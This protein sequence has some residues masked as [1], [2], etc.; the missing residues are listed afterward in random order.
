MSIEISVKMS[1][2]M[3]LESREKGTTRGDMISFSARLFFSG[4]LIFLSSCFCYGEH[5]RGLSLVLL[6]RIDLVFLAF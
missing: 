6:S 5:W 3:R 1:C 2:M 4:N